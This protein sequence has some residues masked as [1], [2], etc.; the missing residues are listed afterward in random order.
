MVPPHLP[1][2]SRPMYSAERQ[3]HER[4]AKAKS[5]ATLDTLVAMITDMRGEISSL[6]SEVAA[7]KQPSGQNLTFGAH[8]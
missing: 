2:I 5:E 8:A 7:L 1:A 6:R 3:M 4:R